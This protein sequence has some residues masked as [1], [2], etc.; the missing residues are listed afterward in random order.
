ML[1]QDIKIHLILISEE[2]GFDRYVFPDFEVDGLFSTH[3]VTVLADE[4]TFEFG[5]VIVEVD[6]GCLC[7]LDFEFTFSKFPEFTDSFP[8]EEVEGS[9]EVG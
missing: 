5:R 2:F 7:F 6:L 3:F 8:K 1:I 4:G 9:L